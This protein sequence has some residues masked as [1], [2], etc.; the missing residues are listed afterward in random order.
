M[1]ERLIIPRYCGIWASRSQKYRA[2]M[3]TQCSTMSGLYYDGLGKC[4]I[5]VY[6]LAFERIYLN[7][8]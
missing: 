2:E 8:L 1:F 3:L 4:F 6:T 5:R 7:T